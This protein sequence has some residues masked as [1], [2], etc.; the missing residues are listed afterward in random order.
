MTKACLICSA[1]WLKANEEKTISSRSTHHRHHHR[2]CCWSCSWS[3]CYQC[4]SC[5]CRC[6]LTL[7]TS[8][9]SDGSIKT[10]SAFIGQPQWELTLWCPWTL[11]LET[12]WTSC[13][14][15]VPHM[16]L[17]TWS[18]ITTLL[19]IVQLCIV[20]SQPASTRVE[21]ERDTEITVNKQSLMKWRFLLKTSSITTQSRT[22]STSYVHLLWLIWNIA[23]IR[24]PVPVSVFYPRSST[25]NL[26]MRVVNASGADVGYCDDEVI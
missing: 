5:R 26:H 18:S 12:C 6:C 3:C 9:D 25:L 7:M 24:L 14:S 16:N 20:G 1:T 15:S 19:D 10:S 13:E 8:V 22:S 4:S 23:L 11:I 2:C 17:T 21:G